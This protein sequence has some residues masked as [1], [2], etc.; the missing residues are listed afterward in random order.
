MAQH[1]KDV[2]LVMD[3]ARA[4][5]ADLPLSRLHRELLGRGVEE[6]LGDLDNSSIIEVLRNSPGREEGGGTASD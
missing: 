1:L 3:L 2:E 5:G 4:A 6:G